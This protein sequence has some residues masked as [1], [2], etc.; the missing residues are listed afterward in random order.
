[1]YPPSPNTS[2]HC[3]ADACSNNINNNKDDSDAVLEDF[4]GAYH[5]RSCNT[6]RRSDSLD[7]CQELTGLVLHEMLQ[8]SVFFHEHS[9]VTVPSFT[10][11]GKTKTSHYSLATLMLFH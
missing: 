8:D 6:L 5:I 7:S 9:T 4:S 2:V 1:M 3:T 11:D 10:P